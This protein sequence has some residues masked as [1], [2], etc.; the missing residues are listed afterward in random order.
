MEYDIQTIA[1]QKKAELGPLLAKLDPHNLSTIQDYGKE[2]SQIISKN[3][4]SLLSFVKSDPSNEIVALTND[5]LQQLNLINFDEVNNS[6]ALKSFLRKVP[7]LN[8]FVSSIEG[9]ISKYNDIAAN[10]EAISQKVATS[11]L[12]AMR[13][14]ST[15]QNVFDNTVEYIKQLRDLILAAKIKEDEIKGMLED[16]KQNTSIE[17]YQVQDMEYVLQ[18]LQKKINDLLI[19]ENVMTQNLYQVRAIQMN[20]ISIAQK[21]DNITNSIIP[22][23]RSQL[24]ISVIMNNQRKGIAIQQKFA[25]T[26]NTILLKNSE[27]LKT[28]SIA[29]AKSSEE[30][31]IS[32]DTLQQTT[33][34]LIE[35]I[36]EVRRIHDE[37]QANRLK[38]ESTINEFGRNIE[39]SISGMLEHHGQ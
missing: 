35:M 5:L 9:V 3:S 18:T 4:D 39:S 28:N 7:I 2:V 30:S 10:V 22:I 24:V 38:V 6:S 33:R 31:V 37:G 26:T 34:N 8:R 12:I 11:K 21:S 13:D 16:M 20:N 14:N 25:E 29:V 32:T 36:Q 23:W 17:P 1:P 27:N 15:L 19:I